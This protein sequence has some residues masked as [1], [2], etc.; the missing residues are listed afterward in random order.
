M[1]TLKPQYQQ[2]IKQLEAKAKEEE[3]SKKEMEKFEVADRKARENYEQSVID[4]KKAEKAQDNAGVD[5]KLKTQ[6][7][8][9][10]EDMKKAHDLSKKADKAAAEAEAKLKSVE[11]TEKA[12]RVKAEKAGELVKQKEIGHSLGKSMKNDLDKA[13]KVRSVA[14]VGPPAAGGLMQIKTNE[15]L[16]SEMRQKIQ[17]EIT[18][19]LRQQIE[20][21]A[22]MKVEQAQRAEQRA[23]ADAKL[24]AG[25]RA[26][27]E[28]RAHHFEEQAKGAQERVMLETKE[29][30]K[31]EDSLR[32]EEDAK[33]AA[34]G[35]ADTAIEAR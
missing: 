33:T 9:E 19:R 25:A 22:Q 10:D 18:Q 21:Q 27:A 30:L 7:S 23:E 4:N 17:N 2:D 14:R 32:R 5:Q 1:S 12:D 24:A 16:E 26:A 15:Q 3:A 20:Q 13:A 34:V 11:K 31:A 28:A 6:F 35:D 29:R 8:K